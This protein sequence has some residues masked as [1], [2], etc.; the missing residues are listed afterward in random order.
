[1]R[2]GLRYSG[3]LT[4]PHPVVRRLLHTIGRPRRGGVR[5]VWIE[6]SVWDCDGREP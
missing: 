1:M 2:F 6:R 3:G 5:D 4:S